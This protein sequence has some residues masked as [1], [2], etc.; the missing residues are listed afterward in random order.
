MWLFIVISIADINSNNLLVFLIEIQGRLQN[1][2]SI[3]VDSRD[4]Q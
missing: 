4:L 1:I 3:Q 2:K